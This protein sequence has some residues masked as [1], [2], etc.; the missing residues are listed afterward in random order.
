[1]ARLGATSLWEVEVYAPDGTTNPTNP[2]VALPG[3]VEAEKPARFSGHDADNLGSASCS[4]TAVD[5]EATSAGGCNVGWTEPGE[6]LEYDVSLANAGKFDLS[7]RPRVEHDRQ[8]AAPG[9]RR[10]ERERLAHRSVR[11]LASLLGRDRARLAITAGPHKL[12]VVMDTGFTQPRLRR[13]EGRHDRA[14]QLRRASAASPSV[15]TAPWPAGALQHRSRGGT[16]GQRR[17][18]RTCAT[19]TRAMASS[20]CPRSGTRGTHGD[21]VRIPAGTKTLL[22]FNEPNFFVQADL[23][24]GQAATEWH[25]VQEIALS[26]GM[27]LA[28][29]AVNFCGPEGSCHDTDPFSYLDDFFQSCTNCQVDYVAA[30]WY[31]CDLPALERYIGQLKAKYPSRPIWLTEFAV[32]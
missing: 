4:T 29:P 16:T 17:R 9:A 30:H 15:A 19:C 28:S 26:R 24:A 27:K 18:R 32:R 7:A 13:G 5:A 14:D 12:R 2:S 6:W 31:A 1:M 21:A 11:R 10:R 20:S 3:R 22:G 25:N 8:V 23:S